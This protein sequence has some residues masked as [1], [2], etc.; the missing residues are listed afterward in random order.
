MY[1]NLNDRYTAEFRGGDHGEKPW[2]WCI[3]DEEIGW[4][5]GAIVFD[6]TENDARMLARKMNEERE[7]EDDG[8]PTPRMSF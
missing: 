5:G 3:V 7:E 8:T 6:L 1:K 2:E 4:C